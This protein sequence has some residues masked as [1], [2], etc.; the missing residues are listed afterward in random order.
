MASILQWMQIHVS[1]LVYAQ[2]PALHWPKNCI[3]SKPC[4]IWAISAHVNAP[5]EVARTDLESH[6]KHQDEGR[7]TEHREAL[8]DFDEHLPG[9]TRWVTFCSLKDLSLTPSSHLSTADNLVCSQVAIRHKKNIVTIHHKPATC[10][11]MQE[12]MH[13]T[14]TRAHTHTL[15]TLLIFTPETIP[16]L[17]TNDHSWASRYSGEVNY[18]ELRC[19]H[20][21]SSSI[22]LKQ[23]A[24]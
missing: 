5:A 24:V 11:N 2:T 13:S 1:A 12:G 14:R 19:L 10:I 21:C 18:L 15:Q 17:C 23:A 6:D 7:E 8:A 3:I 16:W 20:L 9:C 22:V 4:F